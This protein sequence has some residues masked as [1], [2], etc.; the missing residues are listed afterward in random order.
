MNSDPFAADPTAD[1]PPLAN[2]TARERAAAGCVCILIGLIVGGT[3]GGYFGYGRGYERGAERVLAH[4]RKIAQAKVDDNL[5]SEGRVLQ[6]LTVFVKRTK[7]WPKSRRD[8][9]VG[10]AEF[11]PG[12][13]EFVIDD[14]HRVEIDHALTLA[15]IDPADPAQFRGV[16]SRDDEELGLLDI[17]PIPPTD[18]RLLD[19]LAAVAE[20]KRPP[21]E[22]VRPGGGASPAAARGP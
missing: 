6:A 1:L 9:V 16:R 22:G 10:I 3:V 15:G 5:L 13:A 4:Y 12:Y 2:A 8:F 11:D 17:N 20:A 18:E 7:R 21:V 19:L 14:L